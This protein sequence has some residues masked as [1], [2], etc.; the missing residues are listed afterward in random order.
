MSHKNI[1]V[2]GTSGGFGEFLT[3]LALAIVGFYMIF[4]NTIV[5]TSFWHYYGH[6]LLGPIII[7]FMIGLVFLFIN[8]RSWIGM[9]LC[10]GAVIALTVGIIMNLRFH[11][12]NITLL[13]ALIMFGLPA[14]GFGLILRSLQTHSV[15]T[16]DQG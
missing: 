6:N 13:S 4:T 2:G 14:V 11:F 1:N 7:L 10:A 9:L 16:S 3:G 15:D 5:S 8:G 12:K